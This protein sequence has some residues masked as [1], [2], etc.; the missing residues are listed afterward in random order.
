MALLRQDGSPPR[1]GRLLL[2]LVGMAGLAPGLARAQAS[3][4][5]LEQQ[6]KA[7]YLL[8][9]TRYVEWPPGVFTGPEAPV[10]LCVVGAEE[11]GAIVQQTVAGRRSKGRRVRVL[12]PDTPEQAGDCHVAFV[13]GPDRAAREWMTALRRSPT[14]T[15]GEGSG[16]LRRGGMIAF[17]I[18]DETVRFEIDDAAVRRSRLQIS[19]RVLALAS[20]R[21]SPA[22]PR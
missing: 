5:T 12:R 9:F 16:F 14:L 3:P 17:V 18:V 20:R 8:N 1:V 4:G 21:A 13:G 7:A 19:S 2:A 22:E 11:F 15:V 10:N 6:V